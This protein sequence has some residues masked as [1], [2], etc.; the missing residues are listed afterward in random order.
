MAIEA[1]PPP[2][3]FGREPAALD[4]APMRAALALARR[5]LGTVWPNPSVGCV[6]VKDRHVIGRGWTGR[7]GR[8]HGETEALRRAGAAARGATAYVTL[9]PC[10][11]WGQTPPCAEPT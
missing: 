1:G 11:H 5:G 3:P 10:S 8:P 2:K 6:I 7:G 4:L 9:E